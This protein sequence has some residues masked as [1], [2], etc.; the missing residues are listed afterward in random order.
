[1]TDTLQ[2]SVIFKSYRRTTKSIK[3]RGARRKEI[4]QRVT[5]SMPFVANGGHGGLQP[6]AE[7]GLPPNYYGISTYAIM[8]ITSKLPESSN[9]SKE[10]FEDEIWRSV[11]KS[12]QILCK[13]WNS[14]QQLPTIIPTIFRTHWGF[15]QVEIVSNHKHH[16]CGATW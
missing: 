4:I 15:H 10:K 11:P 3:S 2:N 9:K 14:S 12:S 13:F 8:S 7:N 16:N 6:L 5:S 1:M